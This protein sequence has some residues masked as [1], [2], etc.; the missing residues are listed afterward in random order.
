MADAQFSGEHRSRFQELL[1]IGEVHA[2]N[3]HLEY[4]DHGPWLLGCDHNDIDMAERLEARFRAAARRTGLSAGCPARANVVDWWVSRLARGKRG[5]YL[6]DLIQRSVELCEELESN[7]AELGPAVEEVDAA[8]G[9]RRDHYPTDFP[10]PYWVYDEPHDPLPAPRD[11]F[12]YWNA[13]IW[14]GFWKLIEKLEQAPKA[15]AE[16]LPDFRRRLPKE[17]RLAFR[18]R[19]AHRIEIRYDTIKPAFECVGYDLG[20]LLANYV[21]DRGL[22]GDAAMRAFDAESTRLIDTMKVSWRES[23]RRLGLSCRKQV[24]K[25]FDFAKPFNRVAADLRILLAAPRETRQDP[26][27][28]GITAEPVPVPTRRADADAPPMEAFRDGEQVLAEMPPSAAQPITSILL[29]LPRIDEAALAAARQAKV[30]PLLTLKRWKRGK[31]ATEAGVG[32]NSVYGYLEGR[33]TLSVENRKAMAEVL[34]LAPE[35]LPD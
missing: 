29:M 14:Q 5:P 8:A 30:M 28:C 26:S 19:V 11:E 12:E 34:G 23:S 31:W 27:T 13:H 1:A 22:T 25:G 2:L 10:V 24:K 20:V 6:E 7:S 3:T 18:S 17:P 16:P 4:L 15:G 21:F 33:R 32:K 9:L 35:D